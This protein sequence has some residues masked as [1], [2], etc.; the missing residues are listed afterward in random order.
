MLKI[1]KAESSKVTG[2]AYY[3]WANTYQRV[4]DNCRFNRWR[5]AEDKYGN[6]DKSR[7]TFD[8]TDLLSCSRGDYF[9]GKSIFG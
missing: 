5:Y 7:S 8:G 2:G 9:E 4:G 1:E 3:L 6:I